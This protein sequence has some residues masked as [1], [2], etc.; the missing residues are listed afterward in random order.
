[1]FQPGSVKSG[2]TWHVAHRPEPLNTALP[3]AAEAASNDPRGGS[4]AGI[5]SW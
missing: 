5:E 3:A 2:G 4:G 1:M